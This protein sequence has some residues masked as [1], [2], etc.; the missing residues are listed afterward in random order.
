MTRTGRRARAGCR[1]ASAARR[2]DRRRPTAGSPR[3]TPVPAARRATQPAA[4]PRAARLRQ[5]ALATPSTARCAAAPTTAAAPSGPGASAM[6]AVAAPPRPRLATYAL[7]RADL[8]RDGAG[9]GHRVGE[10]HY[11]H[12]APGGAPY[13]DPNAMAEALR[14]GRRR[15]RHPAHAARHLLPGRRPRRDGTAAGRAAAA[16]RR[17][18]RRRVGRA[19][20]RAL[21]P[22]A[23]AADRRGDPLGAGGARA[24]Q[25]PTVVGRPRAAGRCTSTCPSSR[26]R[27]RPAS[28]CYGCTPTALLRRR[29]RARA[30]RPP[31][32]TPPT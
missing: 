2:A 3:S 21:Q 32:C 4:R 29:R 26:P 5:R 31:P 14:A 20:C 30:A 7:A 8:R 27:T 18:R 24:S 22:S 15:R 12:H 9:R 19:R 10:F 6:Y 28:P 23:G 13:A 17:R 25:L 1:R 11:L 16:V